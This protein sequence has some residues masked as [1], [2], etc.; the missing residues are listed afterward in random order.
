[1]K[2]PRV[3]HDRVPVAGPACSLLVPEHAA[4]RR[5]TPA[6][7][8]LMSE[9]LEHIEHSLSEQPVVADVDGLDVLLGLS[10]GAPDAHTGSRR[11]V[12]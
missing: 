11:G 1:M 4:K 10:P 9:H 8:R 5:E 3:A 12:R 7:R 6:A 2:L